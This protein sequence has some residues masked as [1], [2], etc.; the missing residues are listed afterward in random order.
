MIVKGK[1]SKNYVVKPEVQNSPE[2]R[3]YIRNLQLMVEHCMG[4]LYK[5]KHELKF[6][7]E[8]MKTMPD[9]GL[10]DIKKMSKDLS[11]KSYEAR[12]LS[13]DLSDLRRCFNAWEE[14]SKKSPHV[15]WHK[16]ETA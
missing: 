5:I 7:S 14:T 3:Q 10:C 13:K 8:E 11:D 4:D 16:K 2:F 9:D 1:M 15:D 12:D 6:A